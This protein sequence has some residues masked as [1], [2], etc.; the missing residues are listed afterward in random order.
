M[1]EDREAYLQQLIDELDQETRKL[2][3]H[4]E[5]LA[6]IDCNFGSCVFDPAMTDVEAKIAETQKRKKM[7][8]SMA[9]SIEECEA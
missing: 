8:E 3:E 4:M 7:V 5:E 1:A 9:K 2:A 6:G